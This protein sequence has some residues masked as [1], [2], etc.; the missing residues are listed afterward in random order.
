VVPGVAVTWC[1]CGHRHAPEHRPPGTYS[2]SMVAGGL[3]L[4]SYTTRFTP[5]TSFTI[6]EE[7]LASTS[8]GSRAQSAVMPSSDVTARIATTLA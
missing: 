2:H 7:I 5:G 3:E 1:E 6:R 8:Y 4:M